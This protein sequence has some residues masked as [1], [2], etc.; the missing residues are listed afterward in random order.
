VRGLG[1]AGVAV[2][3]ALCGCGDSDAGVGP[4]QASPDVEAAD[5]RFA[6]TTTRVD[7]GTTVEWRN[8]GQTDHTVKGR[9]FFSRAVP[10]GRRYRHRF[11][12]PGTYRYVCTLHP[13]AM[14]GTVVVTR[15][16]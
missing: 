16:P 6:P 15:A 3:L 9:G 10:P 11:D 7:A 2:A 12:T 4:D 5:F 14:E 13:D 1:I 8:S